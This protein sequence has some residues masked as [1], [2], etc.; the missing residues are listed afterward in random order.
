MAKPVV[1]QPITPRTIAQGIAIPTLTLVA[2]ASPT[3]WSATPL[4]A[5]ISIDEE[6]GVITGT[7]TASGLVSTTITATNGDGTS[8]PVTL[9]WNVQ[10]QPTGAG[11]WSDLE[12]DFDLVTRRVTIPGV[13]T[14][15]GQPLFSVARDDKFNIL[16]GVRKWGVLRD[17]KPGSENVGVKLAL[18]EFAPELNLTVA[19]AAAAPTKVGTG[20]LTRFRT[21]VWLDPESWAVLADYEGDRKTSLI[22]VGELELTVGTPP[23]LYDETE[24]DDEIEL[25]GG[26]GGYLDNAFE[27]T[28]VFTGLPATAGASYTLAI[29]L[30]VTGRPG[31]NVGLNFTLDLAKPST[32][33][34]VSNLTGEDTIQGAVEG[35]AWR[36]TLEV[37]E[38]AGDADS[39]DVDLRIST[40][41]DVA[42]ADEVTFGPDGFS[43]ST[44]GAGEQLN[45]DAETPAFE[46]QLWDADSQIGTSWT[47][48]LT[49]DTPAAFAAALEAAWEARTG[50]A[51]VASVAVTLSPI[52]FTIRLADT[53]PVTRI[54]W[55]SAPTEYIAVEPGDVEGV[56][57]AA[58]V[59]G[60]LTQ[61]GSEADQPLRFT[62]LPIDIE[63]IADN[64][65]D[66]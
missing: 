44:P 58:V 63:V 34:V 23:D 52:R 47:P 3:E 4:P 18:K 31:Q 20:D 13:E 15:P 6:T 30:V 66:E 46:L 12:L 25:Y 9:V 65:V 56:H 19:G 33:W 16:L 21:P 38:V 27:T 22:A 64:V 60:Q 17:V 39:V 61:V 10:A 7:P 35:S 42:S 32:V 59:T 40:T 36:A 1:S 8:D 11:E 62:S 24:T 53:S 55:G 28:L 41:A 45:I 54:R 14:Q 43:Q 26:L 57:R 51:D 37:T 48:E 49:Y 29:S 5:G 2:S 50:I